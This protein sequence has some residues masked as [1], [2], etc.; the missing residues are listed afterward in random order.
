MH[1]ASENK[2]EESWSRMGVRKASPSENSD[3]IMDRILKLSTD[4]MSYE[5]AVDF[6]KH[7]LATWRRFYKQDDSVHVEENLTSSQ[8]RV[9]SIKSKNIVFY[10]RERSDGSVK[11]KAAFT[12]E[13]F[14]DSVEEL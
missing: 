4:G 10:V 8:K 7:Q 12:E 6:F 9:S 1:Y 5:T 14:D 2:T 3:E 13:G 11:V